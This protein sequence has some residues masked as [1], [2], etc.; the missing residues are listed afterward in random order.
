MR[1]RTLQIDAG[2]DMALTAAQQMRQVIQNPEQLPELVGQALDHLGLGEEE[3]Q[4][5]SHLMQP[6]EQ[7]LHL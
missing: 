4:V 5:V 1:S 7:G 3:K 6:F 2:L